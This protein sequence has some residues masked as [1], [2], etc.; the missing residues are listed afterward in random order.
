M[1]YFDLSNF[2]G[3]LS[4]AFSEKELSYCFITSF[5]LVVSTSETKTI[6]KSINPNSTKVSFGR[7]QNRQGS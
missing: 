6:I 1:D 3:G 7:N 5:R 2:N 4:A